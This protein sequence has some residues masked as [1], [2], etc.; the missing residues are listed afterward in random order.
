M[1]AEPSDPAGRQKLVR[2]IKARKRA[3]GLN[4][5]L[6]LLE[7]DSVLPDIPCHR[8]RDREYRRR[9]RAQQRSDLR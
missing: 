3:L 4:T 5:D 8:T 1:N 6:T 7:L 9:V 2:A